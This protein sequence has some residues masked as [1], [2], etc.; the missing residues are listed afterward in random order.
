MT[1]STKNTVT[2]FKTITLSLTLALC[3]LLGFSQDSKENTKTEGQTITVTVDNVKNNNGKVMVALHSEDTFMRGPGLQNLEST[4]KEGKISVTFKNVIAGNYA[5]MVLHD[6]NENKRMDFD[7]GGMPK[8][9]YGMSNNPISYGPPQF[10][11]AKF[12]VTTEN[13][14][15][16]IRF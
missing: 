14:D 8:E 10:S 6:E 7:N 12:K 11:E 2:T 4:I 9:S 3:S 15:L 5:I 13:L 1:T 16:N